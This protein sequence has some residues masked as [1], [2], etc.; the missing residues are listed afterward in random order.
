MMATN[1]RPAKPG[2]FFSETAKRAITAGLGAVALAVAVGSSHQLDGTL[3][4]RARLLPPP[5]IRH[6]H[7]GFREAAADL[8]WVR[9]LQDFDAC[10]SAKVG[11]LCKG[12]WV[13]RM[14]DLI[15]DLAPEFRRPY[16]AGGLTLSILVGDPVGASK[17]FDKAVAAFPGD[18][19]ILTRAAYQ[20]LYDE[21]NDAKAAALMERA[22]KAGA[23]SWY[24]SLAMRLYDKSGQAEASR[25]LLQTLKNDPTLPREVLER[26][27]ARL[28]QGVN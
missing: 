21:K 1:A 9:V 27:E 19:P 13:F 25:H 6:F 12:S 14:L 18:W 11:E 8:L 5:D 4:E 23:P 16:A 2:F 15:T 17:L 24:Y 7:F 28:S 3:A 26:I 10:E 20:A 22:A